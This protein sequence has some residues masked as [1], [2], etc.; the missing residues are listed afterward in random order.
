MKKRIRFID[1]LFFVFVPVCAI[2]SSICL[3]ATYDSIQGISRQGYSDYFIFMRPE[4]AR[5]YSVVWMVVF[6]AILA[7]MAYT[8]FTRRKKA[9]IIIALVSVLFYFLMLYL[10]SYLVDFREP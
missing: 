6:I 9:A 7:S 5:T 1:V 8:W 10:Y 4:Q 3:L 2:S